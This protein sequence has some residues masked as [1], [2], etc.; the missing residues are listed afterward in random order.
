MEF[1]EIFWTFL[2]TSMIGLTI[3]VCKLAYKSKCKEVAFCCLR[4]VRDTEL[5]EKELEFTTNHKT[6]ESKDSVEE[7]KV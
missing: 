7:T 4:I 6:N 5:E 2:I 1:S 3:T